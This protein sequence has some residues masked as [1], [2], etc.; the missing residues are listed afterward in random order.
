MKDD[1]AYCG[2]LPSPRAGKGAR[3]G[4]ADMTACQPAQ[5]TAFHLHW[6]PTIWHWV[7]SNTPDR[8]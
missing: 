7:L 6:N 3:Q 2:W 8:N 5:G 4:S 1:Y